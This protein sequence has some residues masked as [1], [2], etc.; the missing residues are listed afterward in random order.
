MEF[1]SFRESAAGRILLQ[2]LQLAKHQQKYRLKP[3]WRGKVF[4]RASPLGSPMCSQAARALRPASKDAR[5][6][7]WPLHAQKGTL[8]GPDWECTAE[9]SLANHS[10]GW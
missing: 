9:D 4:C 10:V 5:P 1:R 8:H 6:T 3:N 7:L 2:L